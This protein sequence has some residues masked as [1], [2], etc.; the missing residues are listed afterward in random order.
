MKHCAICGLVVAATV[1][2]GPSPPIHRHDAA[3]PDHGAHVEAYH[4]P[5]IEQS[6]PSS[7]TGVT[8]AGTTGFA[9]WAGNSGVTGAPG[10]P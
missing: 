8:G 5:G 7:A 4:R 10:A 1:Y 2:L 6:I 3:L 9:R